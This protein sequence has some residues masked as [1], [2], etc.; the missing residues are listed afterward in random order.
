MESGTSGAAVPKRR[1]GRSG[2]RRVS[3]VAVLCGSLL[4]GATL[5]V[6]SP[7]AAP[8]GAAPHKVAPQSTKVSY[9]A[10]TP[11][12]LPAAA[13]T[14]TVNTTTDTHDATP[15]D[16]ICA[17]SLGHCSLRAAIE[18]A[19]ALQTTTAVSV[20]AG[21]YDLTLGA[22]AT[23]D[24]AGLLITGAGAATTVID[25]TGAS[26]SVMTVGQ[27]GTPLTGGFTELTGVTM[28]GGSAIDGAGLNIGDT[29][30]TAVLSGVVITGNTATE[31]GGGVYVDGNLW[32][33][34]SSF[35][36]NTA[37]DGG[38][39]YN[40]SG[41]IRLTDCTVDGNS[42]TSY[43][44]GIDADSG[45]TAIT[46]GSISH[47]VI[48]VADGSFGEGAGIWAWA[49]T[50]SGTT[51]SG[52]VIQPALALTLPT[53]G[54]GAGMYIGF[55][56]GPFDMLTVS[57][58][59]IASTL[60]GNGG[61]IFD[62]SGSVLS[63][64]TVSG[65]TVTNGTGGG[66]YHGGAPVLFVNGF[67]GGS[68]AL[69]RD[70]ITGNRALAGPGQGWGGGI[71]EG[72]TTKITDSLIAG[73]HADTGGGGIYSHGTLVSTGSTVQNN[74][75]NLGAGLYSE[76]SAQ[77][78]NTTF[79]G[80]IASGVG[81]EGGAVFSTIGMTSLDFV[82]LSA[83]VSDSGAGIY[84]EA[85]GVVAS[86]IV[87]GN[88]SGGGV[89]AECAVGGVGTPF[90][91]A[92]HNVFGDATCTHNSLDQVSTSAHLAPIAA[93]G[94][95]TPTFLPL[96]GSPVLGF[97]G[98]SCP[99]TDQRG[100]SRPHVGCDSGSVQAQGYRMV[101]SDG[102]IFTFG[103]AAFFG[104][105]GASHL[106]KPI[107]GMAATPDSQGYWEVAS[108]G[109]IFSFGDAT[110][111]GSMGAMTL[112]K[113][114]VGMATTPDGKGYWEVASD[115]GIFSF[116]DATFFGSMGAMTLNKPIV[117]MAAAADGKGYWEVASDGGIFAFG[118]AGFYG[119]MGGLALN[120]PIVGIAASPGGTGYWEV[121]TDGGIFAFGGATFLGS[122][123]GVPLNKPI[124]G[125]SA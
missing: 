105:M 13:V 60:D 112:N 103:S 65:N 16:G 78:E 102:G 73:N 49:T 83:N 7:G 111:F 17:D 6:T 118:S 64:S 35:S 74:T 99:A 121:A 93:N 21:T 122:M 56:S 61:G 47:N 91:S 58:N 30:D 53:T 39:L 29:S 95:S 97:G 37:P 86:S 11:R 115:G 96:A 32:A 25:A 69:A 36:N 108:D 110:F 19:D 70:T 24:A 50:I 75:S 14:F 88:V 66:I 51:I 20:P 71:S 82:T 57:D 98:V 79:A 4:I 26:A 72:S 34:D 10:K 9:L 114:I 46:G 87:S 113:P 80:N 125:I 48:N 59:T 100:I 18:E 45:T 41:N 8:A 1:Q 89:E 23:T 44:G 85:G 124:V 90:S 5:V 15:G 117:G 54:D 92:G 62:D 28:Q 68:E 55:G 116:G 106:N 22:L 63:D 104:S 52:N 81:N 67:G 31:F 3:R 84:S 107:V 123:G 94:G 33:T 101:A 12:V 77:M 76:S 120:K 42:T 119:S 38:G 2:R 43:G 109:G 40:N 27:G